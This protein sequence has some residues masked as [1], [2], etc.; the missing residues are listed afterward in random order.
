MGLMP[1]MRD[2]AERLTRQEKNAQRGYRHDTRAPSKTVEDYNTQVEGFKNSAV[3]YKKYN[4]GEGKVDDVLWQIVG[5]FTSGI[6]ETPGK[7]VATPAD[8]L[9]R[10]IYSGEQIYDAAGL[11]RGNFSGQPYGGYSWG[12]Q[13]G[14]TLRDA[15]GTAIEERPDDNSYMYAQQPEAFYASWNDRPFVAPL[16]KTQTDAAVSANSELES[17]GAKY[18]KTSGLIGSRAD[19]LALDSEMLQ[20]RAREEPQVGVGPSVFA[21]NTN[22]FQSIADWLK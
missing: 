3:H 18:A 21:Q 6:N 12:S 10:S 2:D 17:L 8:Q 5:H 11:Y 1:Q 9:G 14:K 22:V 7:V 15:T 4:N 20:N 16:T 13:G 19:R